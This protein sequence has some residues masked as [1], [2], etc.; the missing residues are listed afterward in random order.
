MVKD[1]MTRE[2][3]RV[4]EEVSIMKASAPFQSNHSGHPRTSLSPGQAQVGEG[5]EV[6]N[7]KAF[8][9]ELKNKFKLIYRIH[10]E[11]D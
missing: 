4:D 11:L 1:W 6:K 2:V 7:E 10:D 8:C 9:A 3:I 5:D